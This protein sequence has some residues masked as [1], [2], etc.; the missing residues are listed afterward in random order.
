M[1]PGAQAALGSMLS[2]RLGGD[3]RPECARAG[4]RSPRGV[5][6]YLSLAALERDREHR[7]LGAL[8]GST[9]LAA[10]SAFS[11]AMV[12]HPD[13]V[14]GGA[15]EINRPRAGDSPSGIFEVHHAVLG[16]G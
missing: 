12:Q 11:F 9:S 7:H 3:D 2:R 15:T 16:D 10:R 14:G 1:T 5:L 6:M 13:L 4:P 8:C